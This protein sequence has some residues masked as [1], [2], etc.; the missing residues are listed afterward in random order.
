MIDLLKL[1]QMRIVGKIAGYHGLKGEIKIYP[2][3]DDNSVFDDFETITINKQEYKPLTRR[4]HKNCILITLE[5]IN[6]L[7]EAE[8]ITGY[9]EADLE[10]E[11]DDSEIYIED[12]LGINVLNSD[13]VLIGSVASFSEA[14]QKLI[15]IK[16]DEKFS[17]KKELLLPFVD[18]YILD[19]AKDKSYI[20][21]K[22]S[23][24]ILEL[25]T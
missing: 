14:G 9:V 5:G 15:T 23:E 2:L 4:E 1:E 19:I 7:T 3:V 20:R 10:E 22:L 6:S 11:L 25:A 18:E 13:D 12:L 16:L 17:D 8:K 24:E 21:V